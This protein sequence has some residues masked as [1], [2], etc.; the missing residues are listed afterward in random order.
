MIVSWRPLFLW[1][2]N[3]NCRP[4][5]H[6]LD[7]LKIVN[8]VITLCSL[9]RKNIWWKG[10][11][12]LLQL[13]YWAINAN[14]T[15]RVGRLFSISLSAI[16]ERSTCKKPLILFV[17]FSGRW[18]YNRS[19]LG[20]CQFYDI[21]LERY[22]FSRIFSYL[23]GFLLS[24]G[25]ISLHKFIHGK[26]TGELNPL[27]FYTSSLIMNISKAIASLISRMNGR[28]FIWR[29]NIIILLQ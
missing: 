27:D 21:V 3:C 7:L 29:A 26:S 12:A 4:L 2:R 11:S 18:Q 9:K 17:I 25:A 20:S 24:S 5:F 10:M 13:F 8:T 22:C 19:R 23:S 15:S 28:D 16:D 6:L 14:F 1:L